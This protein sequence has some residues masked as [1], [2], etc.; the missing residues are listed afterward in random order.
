[1]E[2]IPI[3]TYII[4]LKSRIDR[5]EHKL[6]EFAVRVEFKIHIVEVIEHEIGAIGLWSF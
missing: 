3:P 4:N 1:M 5:K 2:T 6:K